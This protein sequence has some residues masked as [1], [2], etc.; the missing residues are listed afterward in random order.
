VL[1]DCWPILTVDAHAAYDEMAEKMIALAKEQRGFR[2]VESVRG[3][4]GFG[5]TVSY[6]ENL[7]DIEAWKANG[8]HRVAQKLGRSQWYESFDIKVCKIERDGGSPL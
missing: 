8:E 7:A 3:A 4:D 5:L 6:W 2:G 1:T